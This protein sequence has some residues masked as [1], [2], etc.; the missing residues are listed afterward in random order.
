[1]QEH[2]AV[3]PGTCWCGC[4]ARVPLARRTHAVRG[5]VAGQPT[6]WLPGH[7]QR[8]IWAHRTPRGRS[9]HRD[10][11]T[12]APEVSLAPHDV[13][14]LVQR[15]EHAFGIPAGSIGGH[16]RT[17]PVAEARQACWWALSQCG[18]RPV[19]LARRF[20]RN[21][22]TVLYGIMKVDERPDLQAIVR[23]LIAMYIHGEPP[24]AVPALL[25][26]TLPATLDVRDRRAIRAYVCST[27][28]GWERHPGALCGTGLWLVGRHA[29]VRAAVEEVLRQCDLAPYGTV[30]ARQ[31]APYRRGEAPDYA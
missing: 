29:A 12:P 1:M 2:P 4:G 11:P 17:P 7:H 25:E 30:L 24:A 20:G 26:E 3:P 6:R 8:L 22:S 27:L 15:T 13:S 21:H 19:W 18:V 9:I 10:E 16:E 5:L 23:P 14:A 28:L 31:C